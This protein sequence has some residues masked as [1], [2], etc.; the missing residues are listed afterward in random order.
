MYLLS[1]AG[2]ELSFEADNA[3]VVM[4]KCFCVDVKTWKRK[5]TV[6]LKH[7]GFIFYEE[8]QARMLLWVKCIHLA[9]K[10]AA[11]VDG[12]FFRSSLSGI[13]TPLNE[14]DAD[15][16]SDGEDDHGEAWNDQEAM[17]G[18]DAQRS[19]SIPSMSAVGEK[20]RLLERMSINTSSGA[21]S[22]T[23]NI[24]HLYRQP[25]TPL[26]RINS[27]FSG[28][29]HHIGRSPRST[30]NVRAEYAKTLPP[31]YLNP[32]PSKSATFGNR[33][34]TSLQSKIVEGSPSWGP[35]TSPNGTPV[36]PRLIDSPDASPTV[37]RRK[38]SKED[39]RTSDSSVQPLQPSS[40]EWHSTPAPTTYHTLSPTRILNGLRKSRSAAANVSA[41]LPATPDPTIHDSDVSE[42]SSQA[43]Q[44]A[45]S[46]PEVSPCTHE[47]KADSHTLH[48]LLVLIASS[49]AGAYHTSIF[50]PIAVVGCLVSQF[51]AN[52]HF[53]EWS[54]AALVVYIASYCHALLGGVATTAYCYLSSYAEF[55]TRQREKR[56]KEAIDV[57]AT[58][59]P[60]ADVPNVAVRLPLSP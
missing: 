38:R 51:D 42:Q 43:T 35:M 18:E 13:D 34:V 6:Y 53:I 48:R 56:N 46:N 4:E 28:H 58:G 49:A 25:R 54:S 55:R 60:I 5:N 2:A 22:R 59:Q 37:F 9:I 12:E 32:Q 57:F 21:S 14:D 24:R 26:D 47:C 3:N 31:A 23:T 50:L 27:V 1:L 16:A 7:Q 33:I 11:T 15:D 52:E 19:C 20:Q 30:A 17:L 8:D 41:K 36:S 45:C 39:I 10:E 40:P 44:S 29:K